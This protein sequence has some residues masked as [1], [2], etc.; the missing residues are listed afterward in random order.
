MIVLDTHVLVWW[1]AQPRNLS[2]KAL[3]LVRASAA[4]AEIGVSTISLFEIATLVRRRRLVLAMSFSSWVAA[5][6]SMS[7]INL[8]PVS[9]EIAL[10]AG[11]FDEPFPGDPA[12]RLIAATA[13]VAGAKLVTADERLRSVSMIETV[14]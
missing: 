3:R 11:D 9:P 7:E 10:A 5:L 2:V 14:W 8:Q 13:W 1:L 4:R 6:R 12:D